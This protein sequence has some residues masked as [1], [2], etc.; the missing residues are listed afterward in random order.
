MS[1]WSSA[2]K[3]YYLVL[4][5]VKTAVFRDRLELLGH[6]E[7]QE[8]QVDLARLECPAALADHHNSRASRSLL[9]LAHRVLLDHPGNLV[10]KDLLVNQEPMEHPAVQAKME[11]LDHLALLA[12]QEN[13][14]NPVNW[15]RMVNRVSL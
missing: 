3:T 6:R 4:V 13:P 10:H 2:P 12:A 9:L 15:E 14:V 7:N 11:L 8:N 1:S 5:T